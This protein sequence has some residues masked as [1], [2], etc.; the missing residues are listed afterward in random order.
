MRG[1]RQTGMTL[2]L[3]AVMAIPAVTRA[4]EAATPREA[5]SRAVMTVAPEAQPSHDEL[6]AD[7][8]R[9]WSPAGTNEQLELALR[10]ASSEKLALVLKAGSYEQANAILAGPQPNAFGSTT[11][12]FVYTP[13]APCRIFDTRGTG[14]GGPLA[15]GGSR[16]F[17]VYGTTDI[18]NQGG[19]AS[20]C[21]SPRGEPRAVHLNLTAAPV[22]GPGNIRIYP[23]NLVTPPSVST[24]N[25]LSN[26]IANA[27]TVQ[28][29]YA[30]GPREVRVLSTNGTTDVIADVLGYFYDADLTVGSGKTQV[31]NWSVGGY[32]AASSTDIW[33][34]ITFPLP[35]ASAP[36]AALA[37]FIPV[38]GASTT[39]CPGTVANPQAA[40]GQVCVY[41][42]SCAKAA[43]SC[44]F[45]GSTGGCGSADAY[46]V[47]LWLNSNAVGDAFCYGTWAVTAP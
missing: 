9:L 11:Q 7:A 42:K 26:N 46:G 21:N 5:G 38:A 35:L 6:A 18:A 10:R 37:N 22:T 4:Q 15:P 31:G 36:G 24:V 29:Y 14:G 25:Y 41:A 1:I 12:D 39:N 27:L 23:Q 20:G 19:N 2:T 33:G 34:A 8:L 47:G 32:S 28:T 30:F 16:D 43:I 17:Y 45:K 44:L 40:A 13:V 3:A